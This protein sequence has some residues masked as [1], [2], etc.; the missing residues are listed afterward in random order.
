M[1]FLN[2]TQHSLTPAQREAAIQR[3]GVTE[4]IEFSDA[5]PTMFAQLAQVEPNTDLEGLADDLVEWLADNWADAVVHLPIVP[6]IF[7][8]VLGDVLCERRR[9]GE[10]LPLIVFSHSRR[11]AIDETLP[12]GS[13]KKRQIFVFERFLTA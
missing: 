5:N 10:K 6:P 7:L 4:F 8:F 3:F 12:D 13:V 2:L 9:D 11:D 1:R